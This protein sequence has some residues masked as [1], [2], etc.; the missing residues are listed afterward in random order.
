MSYRFV[1][2]DPESQRMYEA[3]GRGTGGGKRRAAEVRSTIQVLSYLFDLQNFLAQP[4]AP[5]CSA[6]ELKQ[7][8]VAAH[9]LSLIHI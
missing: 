2:C 5:D 7:D 6:D 4:A 8:L 3:A 9:D 1:Q